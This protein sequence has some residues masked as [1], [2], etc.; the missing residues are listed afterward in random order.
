MCLPRNVKVTLVC[1]YLCKIVATLKANGVTLRLLG[2]V[3][4]IIFSLLQ[5]FIL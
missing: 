3:C 5:C 2:F 1:L 4:R